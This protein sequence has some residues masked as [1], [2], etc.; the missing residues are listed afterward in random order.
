LYQKEI[1]SRINIHFARFIAD[2]CGDGDSDIFLAAALV[3][4]AAENGDV[5]INLHDN[6]EKVILEKQN[7]NDGLIC[8]KLDRW[9]EKI[10]ASPVT[11]RPGQR[12]PLILDAR[13]RLYLYRNW[14]YE[15]ILADDINSRAN[16]ETCK[17]DM[18]SLIRSI[19]KLYPKE[20]G[21]TPDW[22]KIAAV[23]ALLK[24]ICIITGGPG[25][26]KTFTITKI[27]ALLIEQGIPQSPK[28]FLAAPTGKA[29]TRLQESIRQAI[30]EL[31]CSKNIINAIPTDV[32]TIHR[33]L[34]P[35]LNSPYFHYHR[36]NK[37]PADMVIIDEA[38]MVD[39]A[40]M[41][42]L[43][44]AIP[45]NARLV[46]IGDKDQLASVEAG[47]VLGDICDRD[48]LHGFSGKFCNQILQ[49]TKEDLCAVID[50]PSSC[51]GLQDCIV[52][53]QRSHRF[54][55]DS[56]IGGL[57]REVN[58]GNVD[59]VFQQIEDASDASIEWH[60]MGNIP[61][62]FNLLAQRLINGYREYLSSADPISAL[63]WL[64][65]Y[66]ILCALRIGPFGVTAINRL[67]EQVLSQHGLIQFD[68]NSTNP[69]YQGRPVL[70]TRND[71]NL[72]LFNGDIGVTL[73]DSEASSGALYVF[74][75][76]ADGGF[77]RYA[78]HRLPEHETVFA[79]TVHKSQGSEFDEVGLILPNKDYPVLTRE[80]VY[81]GLTRAKKKF[82]IWAQEPVL[83]NTISRRISRISGLREALWG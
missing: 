33:M 28:I 83:R 29:A 75:P 67:A 44:Q 54:T 66:K 22:Q 14:E 71:Y 37:L 13:N 20:K 40:L 7:G 48:N 27:M 64:S 31:N 63:E 24:K 5:C 77:R 45:M 12:K 69:W 4:H 57:S 17:L 58:R 47:S 53:L 60:E 26:G 74:F 82:T 46:L 68:L 3:S 1:F 15:N 36:E 16:D 73:P 2:L 78:I 51:P 72:G 59:R 50:K 38:S 21:G 79:M 19:S 65:R 61:E 80:L 23:T 55:A 18:K 10:E 56:G 70:I 41:S 52:V 11:G 35:K 6:A 62:F 76:A 25:T 39:L 32:K 49:I 30:P 9:L 81:T 34:R 43:V 8:P 42:K